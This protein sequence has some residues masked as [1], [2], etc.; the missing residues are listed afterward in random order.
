MHLSYNKPYKPYETTI[1]A[2]FQSR[3][4]KNA[5]FKDVPK[6]TTINMPINM[7]IAN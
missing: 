2:T 6:V 5:I 1:T 7:D 3:G 4:N